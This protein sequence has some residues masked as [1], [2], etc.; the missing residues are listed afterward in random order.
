MRFLV[1][2]F[3]LF[4]GCATQEIIIEKSQLQDVKENVIKGS[5]IVKIDTLSGGMIKI[6]YKD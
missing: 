3:V 2:G 4:V 1:V 6:K 5:S